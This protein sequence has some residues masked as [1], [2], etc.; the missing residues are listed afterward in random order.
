MLKPEVQS[1]VQNGITQIAFSRLDDPSVIPLWFGEGDRPTPSFI[2]DAAKHALDAGE[3]FYTHTRGNEALRGAIQAY[4]QN[5]YGVS[6]AADRVTV[7]G[8]AMLGVNLAA[9]VS[10]GRG[11][12][13][14]IISP[15]WPN[16]E[17]VFHVLGADVTH[18]RQSFDGMGW[19]LDLQ[20]LFDAC[21]ERTRAMFVN[22]PCNPTGWMLSAAEQREI[23]EFARRHNIL[24][25]ADEVYHR[26][27][28]DEPVAPSF[29]QV[30]SAEDPLI[31]VNSFSKAWAMTGWRLGWVVT[32]SGQAEKWTALSECFNTGS[33]VF[34]QAGGVAALTAGEPW[35]AQL[36]QQYATAR[37]IVVDHFAADP[38]IECASPAG[39]FY[40]FPR[41]P[42]LHDSFDFARRLLADCDVGIAPGA[43]FGP[44]NDAFFRLC[45]AQSHAVLRQGLER[46]SGFAAAH[47]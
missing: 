35:V 6:V 5:L 46:L 43:A 32:P 25:I 45:F 11:D 16:I 9:Q 26:T 42:G 14:V 40:V 39:A 36:Q 4:L 10:V 3:T 8:A 19:Q 44:A 37:Q 33:T 31:V 27:V 34:A 38:H 41:L 12:H 1:L 22:S 20:R 7:P 28:F 17:S 30:A 13:A 23:M 29:L 2:R 21:N 47:A 18:V 15:V 24:V